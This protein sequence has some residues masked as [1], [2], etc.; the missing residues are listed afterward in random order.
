MCLSSSKSGNH[1]PHFTDEDQGSGTLSS[2]PTGFASLNLE[3]ASSRCHVINPIAFLVS[4]IG[5][6]LALT[7][8]ALQECV[9][10]SGL[11]PHP[12]GTL[13]MLCATYS[14]VLPGSQRSL[15]PDLTLLPKE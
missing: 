8:G 11:R 14:Q 5:T 9:G 13:E 15:G 6:H 10:F 1:Y 3:C 2:F 4:S 12:A 7:Q